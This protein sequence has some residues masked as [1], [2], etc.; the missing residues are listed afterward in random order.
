MLGPTSSE[1]NVP[2]ISQDELLQQGFPGDAVQAPSNPGGDASVPEIGQDE[3]LG[4][5]F[6]G[7]AVE[8]DTNP[9][10]TQA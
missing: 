2:E 5:Q 8:A 10:D 4:E 1:S 3:L 9:G 7:D 6:P